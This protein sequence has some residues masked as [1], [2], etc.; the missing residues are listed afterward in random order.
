MTEAFS[1]TE[2]NETIRGAGW[3]REGRSETRFWRVAR[4]D[5]E[6]LIKPCRES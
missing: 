2:P 4:W 5:Y 3:G 1:G 6:V